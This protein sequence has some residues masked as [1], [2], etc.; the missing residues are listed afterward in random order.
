MEQKHLVIVLLVAA[1]LLLGAAYWYEHE[2]KK[3]VAGLTLEALGF[4]GGNM[5]NRHCIPNPIQV[6]ALR[7]SPFIVNNGSELG[8]TAAGHCAPGD[9]GQII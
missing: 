8:L 9:G 2:H 5:V 6:P 1:A 3:H 7:S 4:Y